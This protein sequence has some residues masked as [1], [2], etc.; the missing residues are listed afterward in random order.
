MT[1]NG[2]VVVPPHSCRGQK[3]QHP[4][5]LTRSQQQ[6][7]VC[8]RRKQLC[9]M[10]ITAHLSVHYTPSTDGTQLSDRTRLS[11]FKQ[12]LVGPL[13]KRVASD[14]RASA[15]KLDDAAAMH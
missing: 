11:A 12:T 1:R 2:R 8:A 5:S 6:R 3:H 7:P 9:S 14:P 10:R 4:A 13:A 15:Q